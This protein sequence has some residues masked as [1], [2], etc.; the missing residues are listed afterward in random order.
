MGPADA[1]A[2]NGPQSFDIV[3]WQC[4]AP[5]VLGGRVVVFPDEVAEHPSALIAEMECQAVTVLQVVPSMLQALLDEVDARDDK[6]RF[7]SLRWMVPTGEALPTELCRRWPERYPHIPV[8]NTYRS[9]ECSDN[10]VHYKMNRLDP[11]HE[12]ATVGQI[13]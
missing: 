13:A 4:L 7:A 12:P 8:L 6:P 9:T 10:P 11:S 1:L 3:V 5:L 2:Q